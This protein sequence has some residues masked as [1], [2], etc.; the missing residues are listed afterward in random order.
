MST[1]L[2]LFQSVVESIEQNTWWAENFGPGKVEHEG[3]SYKFDGGNESITEVPQEP[4]QSLLLH[5]RKLTMNDAPEQMHKIK[6]ELNAQAAA[7]FDRKMLGV[8]HKFWRIA[9]IKDSFFL[10]RNGKREIMTPYRV[11]HAFIN[12]YL[13]HSNDAE[14]N[15]ILH[16]AATPVRLRKPMLF[17]RNIFHS[18]VTNLCFAALG[19]DKYVKNNLHLCQN[20]P[21][22]CP[23][24]SIPVHSLPGPSRANERTADQLPIQVSY[25]KALLIK[26]L[27]Q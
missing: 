13:F 17:L 26:D 14:L 20:A 19:L 5:V 25:R 10:E 1:S 23:P 18:T 8:W 27:R 15:V 7:E 2:M 4:F 21:H 6:K 22:W 12:G 11:Y 16:G 24:H 3:F 9:F